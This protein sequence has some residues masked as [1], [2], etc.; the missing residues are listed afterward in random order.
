MEATSPMKFEARMVWETQR[1]SA[2]AQ[3]EA[4]ETFTLWWNCGPHRRP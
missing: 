1:P 3:R 4:R 2:R